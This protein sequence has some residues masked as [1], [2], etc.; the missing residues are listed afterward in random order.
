MYGSSLGMTFMGGKSLKDE[1]RFC[2]L[3][4]YA[5]NTADRRRDPEVWE[6]WLILD[7]VCPTEVFKAATYEHM[8]KPFRGWYGHRIGGGV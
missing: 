1:G 4:W 8:K 6:H 5:Q 3:D 2:A 7:E